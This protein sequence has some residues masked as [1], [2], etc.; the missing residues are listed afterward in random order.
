[1]QELCGADGGAAAPVAVAHAVL[2]DGD[3]DRVRAV[4]RD[5]AER[6]GAIV[7]VHPAAAATPA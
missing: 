1:M 2:F 4:A 3:P 5:L 6:P 7:P